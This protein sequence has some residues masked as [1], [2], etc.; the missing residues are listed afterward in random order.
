[1]D[2]D[3]FREKLGEFFDE[4]KVEP[5]RKLEPDMV[6]VCTLAKDFDPSHNDMWEF[7]DN[8]SE[9]RDDVRCCGCCEALAVSNWVYKQ[10]VAMAQKPKPYCAACAGELMEKEAKET[11]SKGHGPGD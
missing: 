2:R 9:P 11:E 3:E 4:A 6:V 1:M 5:V 10:Y 8:K 7:W